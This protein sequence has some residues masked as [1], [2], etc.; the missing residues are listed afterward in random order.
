MLTS[1]LLS[2]IPHSAP[3]ATVWSYD[4]HRIICEIAWRELTAPAKDRIRS[5]L[6]FDRKYD[7]FSESCVWPDEIRRDSTYRRFNTAHYVN[8]APGAAGIDV[9]R[10]CAATFCVVEAINDFTAVLG[11]AARPERERMEALKFL[12]HFVGDL[13]QPLH[14]GY[15]RDLGGNRTRLTFFGDSLNLHWLWDGAML[16]RLGLGPEDAE[17]LHQDIRP[18]DRLLWNDRDPVTWANESFALVEHQVYRGT[19]TGAAGDDYLAANRYTVERRLQQAGFR[20]GALL[21]RLLGL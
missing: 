14:A 1:L 6:A 18:V 11:D 9:A 3:P 5:L 10:D 2:L 12:G 20:L 21:N 8:L 7:R 19:E 15:G 16:Q 4:G 17:A 13:H